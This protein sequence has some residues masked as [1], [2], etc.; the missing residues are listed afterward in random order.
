MTEEEKLESV[1][2]R[3]DRRLDRI[4]HRCEKV[5]RRVLKRKEVS[6]EEDRIWLDKFT[7][8]FG[9]DICTGDF[10]TGESSIGIDIN[11]TIPADKHIS[12]DEIVDEESERM[13]YIVCNY[14]D[15]FSDT[16][17]VLREW[18]RILKVGGTLAFVC[19][20]SEAFSIFESP[21]PLKNRN[22]H[23]LYT[24][25]IVRFYLDRLGFD[26]KIIELSDGGKSIRVMA[27]KLP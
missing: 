5:K 16:F 13:D 20:N 23:C 8:G 7:V 6:G 4:K 17:K 19:R 1:C 24:T 3:V 22:R 12:G 11:K 26:P 18:H 9:Y 15:T 21:G 14:I 2:K 25:K 10:Q 27:K